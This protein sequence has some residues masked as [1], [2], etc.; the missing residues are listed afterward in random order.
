MYG[1]SQREVGL[2]VEIV[3]KWT[4]FLLVGALALVAA[5]CETHD[6]LPAAEF[7]SPVEGPGPD[8]IIGPLD[9]VNVFVWRNQ[10]VTTTVTVRPDGRISVPLIEDMP[11]TGKTPT[12]LARDIEGALSKYIRNPIVT[13][14]VSGFTGPFAQQVRVVG[15]ATEPQAI[16]FRA[17]M[18]LLDVMISVGG[19]TEYAAGNRSTLVRYNTA[20]KRQ[21][22][23]T[24]RI[25]DLIRDGDVSANVKINPGD[26]IIIPESFF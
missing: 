8:Y 6:R 14:I 26:V 3:M 20:S 10:E 4:R 22:E 9:T 24:V 11:A 12:Q 13:V 25:S 17:N 18:T 15:E 19:L 1:V 2:S 5:A 16:P 7:V 23:Y 21:E